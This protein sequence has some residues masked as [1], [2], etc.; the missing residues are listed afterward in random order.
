MPA[1]VR[2]EPLLRSAWCVGVGRTPIEPKASDRL[3]DDLGTLRSE[4]LLFVKEAVG[5]IMGSKQ[6]EAGLRQLGAFLIDA[7]CSVDRDPALQL[8]A[9]DLYA[10]AK[11]IVGERRTGKEPDPRRRRLLSDAERRFSARFK[12]SLEASDAE[13]LRLQKSAG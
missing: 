7:L 3:V 1:S 12:L 10:A 2:Y 11:V 4:T 8:A 9:E 5:L 13:S 6:G